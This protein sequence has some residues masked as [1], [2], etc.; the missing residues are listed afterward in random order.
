[1]SIQIQL[2]HSHGTHSQPKKKMRTTDCKNRDTFRVGDVRKRGFLQGD[3]A[4]DLRRRIADGFA[5]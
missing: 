5:T 4:H 3:A 1:L 2:A